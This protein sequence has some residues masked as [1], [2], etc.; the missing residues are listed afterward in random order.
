[1]NSCIYRGLIFHKRS[2]P[3]EH[4]FSYSLDYIYLDLDEIN[5][6]FSQS[7]LWSCNSTNLVSFHR[8]DYLPSSRPLKDEVIEQI[9]LATGDEFKGQVFL[10]AT[11][12]SLGY[13]L[14]PIAL[15][16]CRDENNTLTHVVV[17]VHNTPW[18]QRHA[19]VLNGPDFDSPTNKAL[20]VSPFMPMDT[21]YE[22]GI[23]DPLESLNVS[24]R[25]SHT[26]GPFF[27]A[28]MSLHKIDITSG[29]IAKLIFSHARQAFRMVTAIYLQALRL[30]IK[31]VPFYPH[32]DK[33]NN[34]ELEF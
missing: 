31:K 17:E 10:L 19:Y 3:V 28:R 12:R 20:H 29:N 8:E 24:I 21:I 13:C 18:N 22:W 9:R 30:W 7:R 32:P 14:N 1:M 6:V 33:K 23:G 16:Y 27:D 25:V 2:K 15:F 11:L 34:K 5:S 26:E 4:S